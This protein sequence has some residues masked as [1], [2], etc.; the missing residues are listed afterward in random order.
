MN[1]SHEAPASDS[2]AHQLRPFAP[3]LADSDRTDSAPSPVRPFA[4][5]LADAEKEADWE[6]ECKAAVIART[7]Y[8]LGYRAQVLCG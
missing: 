2:P 6:G 3:S 8:T 1:A 5:S 4:P 7:L